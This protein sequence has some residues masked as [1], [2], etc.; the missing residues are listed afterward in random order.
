MTKLESQDEKSLRAVTSSSQEFGQK[1]LT[2]HAKALYFAKAVELYNAQFKGIKGF[3]SGL[4]AQ[5]LS[6]TDSL[7]A[8]INRYSI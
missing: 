2:Q 7:I 1:F 3:V 4:T 5:D 8:A 6:D